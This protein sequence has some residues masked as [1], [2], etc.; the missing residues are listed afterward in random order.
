MNDGSISRRDFLAGA[1]MA[2]ATGSV[3]RLSAQQGG[4]R[5]PYGNRSHVIQVTSEH[6]VRGRRVHR[7]ILDEMLDL[8]LRRVSRADSSSAA[9]QSL[10]R[11]DD[12]I[13]LKFNRSAAEG[14][15]VREPFAEAVITSLLA[16]GYRPDQIVPIEVPEVVYEETGCTRPVRHW[17][18]EEVSF[19]SGSDRL[20]GVLE[21]VTAIINVPF[22]KTH[23]IAGLTCCLKNLSHALVKHPARYHDRHCSPYVADI[24]ALPQ[25]R[26][27]L[28]LH[29]VN[30]L[31]MI[32]EG[33]PEAREGWVDAAGVLLFGVDPVAVAR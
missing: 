12:V 17:S 19:G 14:L 26:S 2:A 33:G 7:R 31:R 22:L 10:L 21:Q 28:R 16:A 9:W 1:A 11:S 3:T 13:G 27:K 24:V 18:P 20:A 4:S 29:V 30:A 23:N 8:A 6:V 32:Y 25:I 5:D 15:G